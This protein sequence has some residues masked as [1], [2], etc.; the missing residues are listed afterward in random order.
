[1]A[2]A[3]AGETA[4]PQHVI[5]DCDP[6]IDDAMALLLAFSAYVACQ[7]SRQASPRVDPAC[8]SPERCVVDAVTTVMGNAEDV[9]M[10]ARNACLIAHMA[11]EAAETTSLAT[12]FV[13]VPGARKPLT[14][15]YGG[16]SGVKVHAENGLGNVRHP[17]AASA[18]PL[19]AG[20]AEASSAA[21][22]LVRRCAARPGEITI[23]ALG[24]LTNVAAACLLSPE[25]PA[26]VRKLIIMGGTV[27]G[28]GNKA[29]AAEAVSA[30][31]TAAPRPPRQAPR[32][33]WQRRRACASSCR[34][35][36]P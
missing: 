32:T 4:S 11:R 8:C 33:L 25:F 24:P 10:L 35:W 16:Q 22:A 12:D 36:R 9:D 31:A 30:A 1:M 17:F 21:E 14:R 15:P 28:R 6:G 13:V 29:P 18:A 7:C 23:V 20:K 2:T 27:D 26:T 3:A 5:I 19:E 34:W